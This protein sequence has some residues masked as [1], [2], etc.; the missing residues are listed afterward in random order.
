LQRIFLRLNVLLSKTIK[1]A[2][3]NLISLVINVAHSKTLGS[4]RIPA[5]LKEQVLDEEAPSSHFMFG[6]CII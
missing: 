6:I 3:A 4:Q 5:T 2:E 1:Y